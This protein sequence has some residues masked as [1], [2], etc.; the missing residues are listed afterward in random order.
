MR[1]ASIGG[2]LTVFADRCALHKAKQ[3]LNTRWL[4]QPGSIAVA[5]RFL[6]S[7]SVS[8]ANDLILSAWEWL[9]LPKATR[10]YMRGC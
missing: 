3:R 1:G 4:Q 5:T 10:P 9:Q 6:A 7:L 2:G 8:S